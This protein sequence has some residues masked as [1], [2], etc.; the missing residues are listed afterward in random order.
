MN[1][2]QLASCRSSVVLK[3][4]PI[5]KIVALGVGSAA[6]KIV[7]DDLWDETYFKIHA[8]ME[9]QH[10]NKS[11]PYGRMRQ[12]GFKRLRIGGCSK[13][14]LGSTKAGNFLTSRVTIKFS[15]KTLHYGI[16][17]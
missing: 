8:Q 16:G 6:H 1:T 9:Q 12:S 2:A 14:Q 5:G 10:Y 4:T 15:K 11:P 7:L 13:K 17:Q 3:S